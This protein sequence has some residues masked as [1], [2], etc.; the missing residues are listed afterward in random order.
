MTRH[1]PYILTTHSSISHNKL[2]T[3][4]PLNLPLIHKKLHNTHR[5]PLPNRTLQ[6]P[7]TSLI[8]SRSRKRQRHKLPQ[9]PHHIAQ[10]NDLGFVQGWLGSAVRKEIVDRV[11]CGTGLLV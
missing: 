4:S 3:L 1:F 9:T 2:N 5:I 10:S 6:L 7:Q 8:P 11:A